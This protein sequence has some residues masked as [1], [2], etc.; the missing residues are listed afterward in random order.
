[1]VTEPPQGANLCQLAVSAVRVWYDSLSAKLGLDSSDVGPV[2][3]VFMME[4][5]LVM[6][7]PV[8]EESMPPKLRPTGRGRFWSFTL[9]LPEYRLNGE[10]DID[11]ESGKVWLWLTHK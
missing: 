10:V 6:G 1:M 3:S 9:R 4:K 7:V 11:Q 5:I 8:P 2:D